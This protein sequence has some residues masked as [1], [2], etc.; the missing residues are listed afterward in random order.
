MRALIRKMFPFII[1]SVLFLFAPLFQNA[2]EIHRQLFNWSGKPS[3][4]ALDDDLT[5]IVADYQRV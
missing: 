5:L 1:L 4:K 3:E 2:T